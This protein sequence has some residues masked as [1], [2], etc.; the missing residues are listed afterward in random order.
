MRPGDILYVPLNGF[1]YVAQEIEI[2]VS[3]LRALL[4]FV[5]VGNATTRVFVP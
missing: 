3:P 2:G 5:N 1:S 4:S